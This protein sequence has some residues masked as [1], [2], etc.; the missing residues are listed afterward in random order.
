[1]PWETI[2]DS[3]IRHIWA[4]DA[5]PDGEGEIAVDP[6]WYSENGTPVDSETGDDMSYVR[7]EILDEVDAEETVVAPVS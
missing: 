6:S 4:P 1:M 2:A 5:A 7:T 3:R